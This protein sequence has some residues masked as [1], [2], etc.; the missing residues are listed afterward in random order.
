VLEGEQVGG[1]MYV[2][3]CKPAEAELAGYL[4]KEEGDMHSSVKKHNHSPDQEE[5]TCKSSISTEQCAEA[6]RK[7]AYPPPEQN[8]TPISAE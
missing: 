7:L 6:H 8:A 2:A 1:I 3:H 4:R 5:S